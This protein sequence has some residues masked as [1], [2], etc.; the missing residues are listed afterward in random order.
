[1]SDLATDKLF[2]EIVAPDGKLGKHYIYLYL[3]DAP[4]S[5][6]R[7]TKWLVMREAG[8]LRADAHEVGLIPTKTARFGLV[9]GPD[10]FTADAG[11]TAYVLVKPTSDDTLEAA[12]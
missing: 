12:F 5:F 2:A 11:E 8:K 4:A 3:N 9:Y 6:Q 10:G 1:M 7:S